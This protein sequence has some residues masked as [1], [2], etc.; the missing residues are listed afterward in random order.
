MHTI[1][2]NIGARNLAC[3][4]RASLHTNL[5]NEFVHFTVDFSQMFRFSA[6]QLIKFGFKYCL[7][8]HELSPVLVYVTISNFISLLSCF[9]GVLQFNDMIASAL[10]TVTLCIRKYLGPQYIM[11]ERIYD[12]KF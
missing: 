3:I 12:V 4:G 9:Y 11:G 2:I 7:L 6:N 8:A 1:D 10:K 5:F